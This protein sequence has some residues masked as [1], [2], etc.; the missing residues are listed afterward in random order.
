MGDDRKSLRKWCFTINNYTEEDEQN[1]LDELT[2]DKVVYAIVG[3]CRP[4]RQLQEVLDV[5]RAALRHRFSRFRGSRFSRYR[6]SS[7]YGKPVLRTFRLKEEALVASDSSSWCMN[8]N[9]NFFN[10]T[11]ARAEVHG[12]LDVFDQFKDGSRVEDRRRRRQR[13]ADRQRRG[14]TETAATAET[15]GGDGSRVADRRRGWAESR[16]GRVGR[17]PKNPTPKNPTPG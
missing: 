15:V 8:F 4:S 5:H 9:M 13:V 14:Q 1:L 12:Y 2:P 11:N 10:N 7:S 3:R 17:K 16:V 6:P